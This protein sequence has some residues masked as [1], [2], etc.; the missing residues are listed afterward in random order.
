VVIYKFVNIYVFLLRVIVTRVDLC[1]IV[2]ILNLQGLVDL[3]WIILNITLGIPGCKL[4]SVGPGGVV[5]PILE[6]FNALRVDR[7][8]QIQAISFCFYDLL[9]VLTPGFIGLF[10]FLKLSGL[11]SWMIS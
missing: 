5:V 4:R 10:S 2:N 7:S 9:P 11:P 6:A 3:D 1:F 8:R